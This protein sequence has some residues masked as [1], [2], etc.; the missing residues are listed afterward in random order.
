[1]HAAI[2][3]L[4]CLANSKVAQLLQRL[5]RVGGSQPWSLTG[6]AR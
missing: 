4:A 1:M 5:G 3:K 2:T 6:S